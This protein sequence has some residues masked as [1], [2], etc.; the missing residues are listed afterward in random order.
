M[1][2][3]LKP[4][5]FCENSN[6]VKKELHTKDN[7]LEVRLFEKTPALYGISCLLCTCR[8]PGRRTKKA[9]IKAWNRRAKQ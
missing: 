9:A 6:K 7:F 3:K 1:S 4:C 2:E 8:G 5:P